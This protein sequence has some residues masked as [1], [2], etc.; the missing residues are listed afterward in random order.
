ML[1]RVLG[2][3]RGD[4]CYLIEINGH[5]VVLLRLVILV[6]LILV[7]LAGKVVVVLLGSPVR[8]EC[9]VPTRLFTVTLQ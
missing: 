2:S 5:I 6:V 9:E 4:P 7:A 1:G 8:E 3:S